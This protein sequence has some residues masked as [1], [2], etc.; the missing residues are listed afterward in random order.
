MS[1]IF[2]HVIHDLLRYHSILIKQSDMPFEE[3]KAVEYIRVTIAEF[4]KLS[5]NNGFRL[6]VLFHPME[7][8]VQK[9]E[10]D[11]LAFNILAYKLRYERPDMFVDLLQH[12]KANKQISKDNASEFFWKIDRHHNAKGYEIMG[13][14]IANTIIDMKLL[15]LEGG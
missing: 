10:Y 5:R 7:N 3:R 11:S 9:E 13:R 12:W 6:L 14:A 2:R 4:E 8:E 1:F 15:E